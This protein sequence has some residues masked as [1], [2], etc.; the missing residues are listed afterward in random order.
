MKNCSAGSTKYHV[1][2]AQDF[3]SQVDEFIEKGPSYVHRLGKAII[4]LYYALRHIDYAEIRKKD[5]A[6]YY[7]KIKQSKRKLEVFAYFS[8]EFDFLK[9]IKNLQN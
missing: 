1:D 3:I 6:K 9:Q 2:S 8:R 4:Y 5:K 7:Q